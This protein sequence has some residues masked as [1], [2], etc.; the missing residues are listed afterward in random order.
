MHKIY[1][2]YKQKKM[3]REEYT[4]EAAWAVKAAIDIGWT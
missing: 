1:M 2:Y 4:A 3:K